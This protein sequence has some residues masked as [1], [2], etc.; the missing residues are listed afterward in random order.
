MGDNSFTSIL[1]PFQAKLYLQLWSKQG[2]IF[3]HPL[4]STVDNRVIFAVFIYK[5]LYIIQQPGK[6]RSIWKLGKV[7][8]YEFVSLDFELN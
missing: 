7:D 5:T 2:S 4:M 6:M 1:L 8:F 3:C